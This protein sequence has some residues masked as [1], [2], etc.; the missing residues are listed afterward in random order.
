MR[1][2]AFIRAHTEQI[3]SEWETF[4]RRV[5]T[6]TP[7]NTAALRDHAKEMLHAVADDL[8]GPQTA[9]EQ[10]EKAEGRRDAPDDDSPTA[11]QQ[12]GAGRALSGFTVEQMVSEFRALRASVLHL[13]KQ[14]RG[15]A[16]AKDLEDLTRFNESIDQAI[17]ESIAT[18]TRGVRQSRDRF[19]AVLGHDLR[20]PVGAIMTAAQFLL[21]LPDLAELH[22]TTI[23]QMQSSA[24]RMNRLI[25]DLI[26]LARTRLGDSIPIARAAVDLG[27]LLQGVV[28]EM[29]SSYPARSFELR[30][31]GDLRGQWDRERLIQALVNLVSNAVHHGAPDRPITIVASG[32]ADEVT[33]S[34]HNEGVPIEA[35]RIGHLFNALKAI[36]TDSMGDRRHLG[37]GLYIVDKIVA[38]HAGRI[39]VRSSAGEG[40][41]FTITL[42]RAATAV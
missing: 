33:V 38:A 40:T 31:T 16:N 35:D 21:D 30:R 36:Q 32:T 37:L 27:D 25:G 6:E 5:E 23:A 12:H 7:M 14:E 39:D 15:E 42:P 2:S 13:W 9:R 26:E 22:R 24:R 10:R 3:L 20:N 18:Y 4:A 29:I 11:A 28:D 41:T 34:V 8:E 17:A 19:L 1:L